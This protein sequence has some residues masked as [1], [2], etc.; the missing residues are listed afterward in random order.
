VPA[1]EGVDKRM[2]YDDIFNLAIEH[3]QRVW[4]NV[5]RFVYGKEDLIVIR[6]DEWDLD[7]GRNKSA[8]D[9]RLVFWNYA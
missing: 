6:G 9:Q 5:T 1:L 2:H 8:K 4:L 3:I 7:T